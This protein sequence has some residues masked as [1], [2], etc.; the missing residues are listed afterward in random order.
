MGNPYSSLPRNAFWKTGIVEQSEDLIDG[1]YQKKFNILPKAKIATAGSCFAQ[2]ISLNLKTN[3][4]NVYDAEP[5]PPGLPDYAHQK[6]GYSMYSARYGNIYTARQL[7]QLAQE[8]AGEWIPQ[9]WIWQKNNRFFD[10]L[11]PS[12]EPGGFSTEEEVFEHRKFHLFRVRQLFEKVDVFIFTLGL[13]EMWSHKSSG[14]VYPVAP[15][16]LAG[17]FNDHV[18]EFQNATSDQVISDFRKFRKTVQRIRDGKKFKIILTV[19]PV[20]LTATSSGRHVLVSNTYSKSAL[21]NAASCLSESRY[22]DY[23]PSYEIVT[24]PARF[25]LSFDE[26]LRTVRQDTIDFVMRH[27]FAQH[28]PPE[29]KLPIKS[30]RRKKSKLLQSKTIEEIHCEEALLEA[31]GE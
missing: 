28:S 21:R 27:F 9:N 24:N 7:L 13:T 20:P 29:I 10:A 16:V 15:G 26:N 5:A 11:R 3:G 18:Y 17:E 14:T 19:S 23:F 2:H 1:I 25:H 4:F 12:V 6:F 8:A 31:F 22:V 30:R